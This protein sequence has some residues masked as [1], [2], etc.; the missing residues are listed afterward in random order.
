MVSSYVVVFALGS[1]VGFGELLNRYRNPGLVFK[2]VTSII[3]LIIN[4]LASV[5]TYYVMDLY[6]LWFDGF[7]SKEID[8]ILFS[9]LSA[10]FFLRSSIFVYKPKDS[11]T[12]INIGIASFI[13]IFLDFAE[14]SFDQNQSIVKLNKVKEIMK[15]VDF[16]LASKDLSILCLT[17]MKNVSLE[18]QQKLAEDIQKM[19]SRELRFGETKAVSLGI[20]ISDVGGVKLLKEAVETLKSKI[21]LIQPNAVSLLQAEFQEVQDNIIKE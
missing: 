14:R 18:E 7:T 11:D 1:L 10:M 5:L 21:S 17:L 15:G 9:G 4:G 8:R 19:S 3:Y 13:Q 6:N 20:L 2:T 12:T 16:E